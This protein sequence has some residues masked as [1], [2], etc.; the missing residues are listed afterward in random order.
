MEV[1]ESY[2][3][4]TWQRDDDY[5]LYEAKT[6]RN[7]NQLIS[8]SFIFPS[9]ISLKGNS[10]SPRPPI[11]EEESNHALGTRKAANIPKLCVHLQGM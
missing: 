11:Y 5:D 7:P 1:V 3:G 2:Q 4:E 6:L 8:L 10:S 9:Q